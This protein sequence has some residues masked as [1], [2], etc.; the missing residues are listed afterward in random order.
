M[1]YR[2]TRI[3]LQDNSG[4]LAVRCLQLY[5]TSIKKGLF[6]NIALVT[7]FRYKRLKKA[8]KR[9]TYI[10]LIMTIKRKIFRAAG[11]YFITFCKNTGLLLQ[12]DK[13]R[14]VGTVFNVPITRE[15]KQTTTIRLTRVSRILV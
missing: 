10:L 8:T 5:P 13:E 2:G 12:P 3:W 15:V 14:F 4:I 7:L 11:G 9:K 1:I 6:G